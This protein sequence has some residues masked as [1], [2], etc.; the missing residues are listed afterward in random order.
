V[1]R[2]LPLVAAMEVVVEECTRDASLNVAE[3]NL[4]ILLLNSAQSAHDHPV[5]EEE[6]SV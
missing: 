6:K 1:G 5:V 2:T 4:P 3:R